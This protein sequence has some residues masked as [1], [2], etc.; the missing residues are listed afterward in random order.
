LAIKSGD[1]FGGHLLVLLVGH[2]QEHLL[3]GLY[4]D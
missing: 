4:P 1:Q 3:G 2:Q